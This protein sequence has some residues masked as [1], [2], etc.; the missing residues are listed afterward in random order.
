[1]DYSKHS[2]LLC[3]SLLCGSPAFAIDFTVNNPLDNTDANLGDGICQS[4]DGSCTLRAAVQEANAS[5]GADIIHL[6]S[7]TYV[8]TNGTSN[9]NLAVEGDLDITGDLTIIGTGVSKPVIDGNATGNVI[10]VR[11]NSSLDMQFLVIQ[12]GL[13]P[14]SYGDNGAGI[15]V[16]P[17]ATLKTSDLELIGNEAFSGGAIYCIEGRLDIN[18][19]LFSG[20]HSNSTSGSGGAGGGS[21]IKAQQGC[22]VSINASTFLNNT[23]DGY[24]AGIQMESGE[25]LISNSTFNNNNAGIGGGAISIF[26]GNQTVIADS[27]FTA[28]TAVN[29]SAIASL[30]G[31]PIYIFKSSFS[32]NTVMVG[33]G[34]ALSLSDAHL[35]SVVVDGNTGGGAGLNNSVVINSVFKNNTK[36]GVGAGISGSYVTIKDSAIFNNTAVGSIGGGLHVQHESIVENTTISGNIA[37]SGGGVFLSPSSS[38]KSH[39][40]TNTTI[41]GNESVNTSYAANLEVWE[42]G[43]SATLNNSIL[44]NPVG[45][46]NCSA[47]MT[48]V[49]NGGNIASD[50]SCGLSVDDMVADAKL[51]VLD[52]TNYM[53]PFLT[54]SPAIDYAIAALCPLTDQTG[55]FRSDGAC[56]TGAY[57]QGTTAITTKSVIAIS[58]SY[59]EMPEFGKAVFTLTR[60][61]STE[62]EVSAVV[63]TRS[64]SAM[65]GNDYTI[66]IAGKDYN[67]FEQ[68]IT[69]ADGDSADKV[70]EIQLTEDQTVEVDEEFSLR[71]AAVSTNGIID[72]TK[73]E[74]RV[75]ILDNDGNYGTISIDSSFTK[76]ENN[77]VLTI[78][79]SRL[80]GSD[81]DHSVDFRSVGGTAL[82]DIDYTEVSGSL[83]WAEGDAED[84][85]ITIEVL[86]DNIQE[87]TEEFTVE[88]FNHRR[89]KY[90]PYIDSST[91]SIE[92][93]DSWA[94]FEL[95]SASYSVAENA[96]S[97]TV[98]VSRL[99]IQDATT[100]WL[101][102]NTRLD[103]TATDIDDFTP[104]SSQLNFAANE[105]S[106]TVNVPIINDTLVE[107]NETITVYLIFPGANAQLGEISTATVTIVDDESGNTIPDST[108]NSTAA[109]AS[110]G[111]GGSLSLPAL[112]LMLVTRLLRQRFYH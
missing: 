108:T 8:L 31:S 64:G 69:W 29:G 53:H 93:D 90:G 12:N 43:V 97:L 41:V 88:L 54:G 103:D 75:L 6:P 5:P 44:A 81:K 109:T 61:G 2:Y 45:G 67:Q 99:G 111:G 101:M 80:N 9:E 110:S 3:L 72:V 66:T 51:D 32:S 24:G 104:V 48:T 22:N 60:S 106:K 102:A 13:L 37:N 4:D 17:G 27:T 33:Y 47:I 7:E 10:N 77:G 49:S 92:D 85:T 15:H 94:F 107:G 84:K 26:H 82:A 57:E 50:D 20:N 71:I 70:V 79:V 76:W 63:T 35:D 56:D 55:A 96:G 21:A 46:V 18:T 38:G 16:S 58:E 23:A 40:F 73:Q 19:T 52:A 98:N 112:L 39:T 42:A 68:L 34:A 30:S 14:G 83:Y 91:V 1:M 36:D 11:N 74:G 59:R 28:N 78:L 95:S 62:G 65:G 89:S 87:G 25:L 86:D 105:S 100:V